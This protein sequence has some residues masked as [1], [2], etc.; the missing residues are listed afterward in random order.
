MYKLRFFSCYQVVNVAMSSYS[1]NGL[2]YKAT[3]DMSLKSNIIDICNLFIC[4]WL[5]LMEAANMRMVIKKPAITRM[6]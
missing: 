5:V 2:I 4:Q 3:M 6:R 1:E